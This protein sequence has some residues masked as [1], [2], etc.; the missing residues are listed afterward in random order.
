[1]N[2]NTIDTSSEIVYAY[3][4]L[5]DGLDEID[6]S[7]ERALD[8]MKGPVRHNYEMMYRWF[9]EN[10]GTIGTRMHGKRLP[11]VDKEFA[12]SAMR[13]IHAPNGKWFEQT[14][15]QYAA[16]VTSALDSIYDEYGSGEPFFDLGDGTWVLF[17]SAHRNNTDGE[18]AATWNNALL[19]N[20]RDGVPVGV[21]RQ[22]KKVSDGYMRAL[23]YVEDFDAAS[24]VF[25][26]HGPVLPNNEACFASP[27]QTI[28]LEEGAKLPTVAELEQ[29]ARMFVQMKQAVRTGQRKFRKK[30][31]DAYDGRCALTGCEVDDVLQ[32]AHIIDYRGQA[33]NIVP[34]GLLLRED[35]HTLYDRSLLSVNPEDL[36]IMLNPRIMQSEYRGFSNH[37]LSIPKQT[38]LQPNRKYLEIHHRKFLEIAKAS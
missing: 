36:S 5:D 8:L 17:Y 27:V 6:L 22:V 18:T 4:K 26:L 21:F 1:M 15:K 16:T 23:A 37:T 11:G 10:T 7:I 30:L 25:T 13:G 3:I 14:G 19:N 24:G 20:L 31:L 2:D 29:D 38:E 12:H 33:S 32:A 34:N 9:V 28:L 35:I